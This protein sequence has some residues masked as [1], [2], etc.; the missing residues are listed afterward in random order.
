MKARADEADAFAL[1]F[2]LKE[3]AELATSLRTDA[4]EILNWVEQVTE[5]L[6]RKDGQFH[7]RVSDAV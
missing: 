2:N 6:K 7:E 5:E 3:K 4:D 1:R